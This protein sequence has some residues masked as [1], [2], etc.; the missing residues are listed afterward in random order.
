VTI[1]SSSA[2]RFAIVFCPQTRHF[3]FIGVY[4]YMA[5]TGRAALNP[6]SSHGG[7]RAP[8]GTVKEREKWSTEET[9]YEITILPSNLPKAGTSPTS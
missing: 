7:K 2:R 6:Q 5:K 3:R 8:G 4:P 9:T 1:T